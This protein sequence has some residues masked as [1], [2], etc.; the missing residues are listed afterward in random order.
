MK[1]TNFIDQNKKKWGQFESSVRNKSANPEEL[2]DQFNEITDDLSYARTFYK[3]RSVRVYLNQVS[4]SVYNS[5]YKQKREGLGKFWD[6]WKTSLPLDVYRSRK[7]I[8]L[9]LVMFVLWTA[10]GVLSQLYNDD[11]VRTILGDTYVNETLQRIQNGDPL[12]IYGEGGQTSTFLAI[13]FNNIKVSFFAFIAGVFWTIGTHIILMGNGIML[14]SFQSWFGT[15]GLLITSILGV[16]IHGA[17]EISAIVIAGGAGM[18]LGNSLLFPGSYTR[19][20]SFMIG[21]KRGIKILVSLIPFFIIAGFLEGFV[22]RNYKELEAWSKVLIILISFIIIIF[23]YLIYPIIVARKNPDLLAEEPEVQP[24]EDRKMVRYKLRNLQE[25]FN[26]G[27][28][29][30]RTKFKLFSKPLFTWVLPLILLFGVYSIYSNSELFM[31]DMP[32]YE[33][34][35]VLFGFGFEDIRWLDIFIWILLLSQLIVTATYPFNSKEE[36]FSWQFYFVF[37]LKRVWFVIP[38]SAIGMLMLALYCLGSFGDFFETF[39]P[40]SIPFVLLTPFFLLYPVALGLE[41]GSIFKAIGKGMSAGSKSW[42]KS[43]GVFIMMV[44]VCVFFWFIIANPLAHLMGVPDVLDMF[45]E[46]FESILIPI[47]ED[48]TIYLNGFYAL[49]Y[50][51]FF[52]VLIPLAICAFAF[53][54]YAVR[55]EKES[56][57][58][59]NELEKFGKRKRAIETDFD[60]E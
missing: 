21:A 44:A 55:E 32:W 38:F 1:E 14:G 30:Y 33:N 34:L 43:I 16:W 7:N 48:Y 54:Y 50:L 2:S 58:L 41:K 57:G 18:T 40:Y 37:L 53:H 26:D 24:R 10:V 19:M 36:S 15:K 12:G 59:Y 29:F 47:T 11:F 39:I 35:I 8:L 46:L 52:V 49:V 6:F 42:W 4:Q 22:T 17:F 27:F 25:V 5:L 23:Y 20:Q 13:T 28:V 31:Y 60:F 45:G 56:I 51:T 3:R 9:A